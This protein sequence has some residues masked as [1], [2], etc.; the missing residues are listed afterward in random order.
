[1]FKLE[2]QDQP[3]IYALVKALNETRVALVGSN[4]HYET[5]ESGVGLGH[6]RN[7]V[8][9]DLA[10]DAANASDLATLI[11]LCEGSGATLGIRQVYNR[12]I[13]DAEAHKQADTTNTIAAATVTDLA[14]AQTFL[15]EV[16]TDYNAHIGSTTFHAA[17]D[18]TNTVTAANATDQATAET[19]ANEI[20]TDLNAHITAALAGHGI[21]VSVP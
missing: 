2:R 16:K 3:L 20:K 8:H 12:H 6:W 13:A 4:V 10:V 19:L 1:M 14:T 11:T 18:A 9:T 17:A 21:R 7:P 5:T 15:N